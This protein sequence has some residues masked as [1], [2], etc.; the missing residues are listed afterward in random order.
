CRAASVFRNFAGGMASER[1]ISIA[2]GGSCGMR[3][4]WFRPAERLYGYHRNRHPRYRPAIAWNCNSGRVD[5]SCRRQRI[6][7]GWRGCCN[8]Y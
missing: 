7:P 6:R 5:C 4:R 2:S 3:R 1:S 8:R